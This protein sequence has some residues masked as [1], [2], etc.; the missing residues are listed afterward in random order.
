MSLEFKSQVG[1]NQ[2]CAVILAGSDSDKSHIDN[3][4]KSLREYEIP[5]EVRICSAHKQP[6]K[7]LDIL[8]EYD[9][10]NGGLVY[11]AVA[12]GT[13]A[14][15]GTISFQSSRPVISSPPD[16]FNQSCVN[17]PAGSSNAYI[18][19]PVNV[20][21]F[22]AQKFYYTNPDYRKKIVGSITSKIE[23]LNGTDNTLRLEYQRKNEP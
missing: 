5:F 14:L 17:N 13:D 16:H 23:E 18:G 19:R 3:L 22:I 10:L 7:L 15:S 12:G 20:A 2:G 6:D 9:S 8:R 4:V 11:I 1:E 21:R